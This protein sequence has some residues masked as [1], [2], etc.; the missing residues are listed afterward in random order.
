MRTS[1]TCHTRA[2]GS[3]ELITLRGH[4]GLPRVTAGGTLETSVGWAGGIRPTGQAGDV[5]VELH[6]PVGPVGGGV[7]LADDEV[8][9]LERR[10]GHE[11]TAVE[12]SHPPLGVVLGVPR[13]A[14]HERLAWCLVQ[15][16]RRRVEVQDIDAVA[17][18]VEER[19]QPAALDAAQAQFAVLA[20]EGDGW[21]VAPRPPAVPVSPALPGGRVG[22]AGCGDA[23]QDESLVALESG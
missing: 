8:Q 22:E 20:V 23:L 10:A 7:P 11:V 18:R 13:G 17:A 4:A 15:V 21:G 6:G 5:R 9:V 12:L 1:D 19:Q 2:K 14:V 16:R 3:S